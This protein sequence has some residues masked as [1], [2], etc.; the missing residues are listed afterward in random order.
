V[1]GTIQATETLKILTGI[2]TTLSGRLLLYDALNLTFRELRLRR[3]PHRKPITELVD[4]EQFCGI[5]KPG[6]PAPVAYRRLTVGELAER[7]AAGWTPFVL[8]VRKPHEAQIVALAFTDRLE[9]HETVDKIAGELPR[10]RDLVVYC[11]SGARSAKAAAALADLGFD[12]VYQLEGGVLAWAREI[13]PT[14]P[15][16]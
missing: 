16:Y 7:R 4:Y 11:K 13:D 9:P 3:D 12:R 6:A 15:S 8:D 14:L 5:T 1:I 2:G 10:D